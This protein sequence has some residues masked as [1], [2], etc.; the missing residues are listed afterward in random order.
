M[1]KKLS[2]LTSLT[3]MEIT[4]FI[5]VISMLMI[6]LGISFF[7]SSAGEAKRKFNYAKED[8]LF[9]YFKGLEFDT[10]ASDNGSLFANEKP[11]VAKSTESITYTKKTFSG[12]L[13]LNTASLEQLTSLPGIGVKTAQEIL[14]YRKRIGAFKSFNELLTIKGIGE[15]KLSKLKTFLRL[16]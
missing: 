3:E 7:K 1:I 6:S 15:K 2:R 16:K 12:V 14:S 5:F 10:T 8:S 11:F 4:I 13:N 9:A